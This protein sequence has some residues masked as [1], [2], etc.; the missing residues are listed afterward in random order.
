METLFI[1]VHAL[2]H[3]RQPSLGWREGK[4]I[5]IDRLHWASSVLINGNI[6]FGGND[7]ES[8]IVVRYNPAS[9]DWSE[10]PKAPVKAFSMTSLNDQLLIVG[11]DNTATHNYNVPSIMVWDSDHGKW[12]YYSHSMP[13]GRAQLAAVGYREH[14]IV[15]CGLPSKSEVDILDTLDGK[16]HKAQPV[17]QGGHCISSAMVNDHWYLSSGNWND[18]Q[19]HI[20]RAHLPT[21]IDSAKFD[22]HPSIASIWHELPRPDPQMVLPTILAS[23]QHLLIAGGIKKKDF[24]QKIYRYDQKLFSCESCAQLPEAMFG[25]SCIVLPSGDMIVAGGKTKDVKEYKR[26]WIFE[27]FLTLFF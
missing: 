21:L 4:S 7:L 5:P 17:P 14:L 8:D 3:K 11:G 20:Y 27:Q 2:Q 24:L 13:T 25:A 23:P 9:D 15:A 18:S 19:P 6:Y 1:V 16:W 10:L 22:E 12:V 26:L